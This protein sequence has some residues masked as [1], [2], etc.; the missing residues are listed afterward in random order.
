MSKPFNYGGQAVI[1]GVMMRG[2]KHMAVAVRNPKGEIVLHSE[3]LNPRI[4]SSFINKVPFLRGFTLLWDALVLGMRTLMFSAEVAMGE[5]EAEFSGP[6][7]WGTV[8][9][10]LL[11]AIAIFFVSPLLL[12]SLIKQF[13]DVSILVQHL[14]EGVVR[15]ALFLGYVWGIGFL[16]EIKR[17]FGY[18][19]AEHKAINA[20]E[21][22]VELV[23]EKVAQCSIVHPRCGTAFL[24]IVMVISI[25]VFAL[26]GD[27]PLWLKIASRIVLIPVIAGIAYEFLKFSAA[28]QKNPIM[29]LLIAPGLAL[30]GMTTREPDLS[31]L[32]VSIAALKKLL[33]E[34][35]L[36]A[37]VKAT[38][39][40]EALTA[41]GSAGR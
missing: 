1:E 7:A 26:V 5:E 15:L 20:Y 28:H 37:E 14:I 33:A 16:A 11:L 38:E 39:P 4:Y 10:S 19:G 8:A 22:G 23:P 21:Q 27:P 17:V 13:V 3:P 32:E 6:V 31:M 29:K 36:A 34:E 24:L 9:F 25:F 18:H 35:Q 2:R 12:I 40:G 41:P 30:Q